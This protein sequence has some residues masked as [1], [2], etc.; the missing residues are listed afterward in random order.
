M[1]AVDNELVAD[2]SK[3][4]FCKKI[5]KYPSNINENLVFVLD[6]YRPSDI[7][8]FNELTEI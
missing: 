1:L 5:Y 2:K 4:R 6:K 3:R 7:D 8:M